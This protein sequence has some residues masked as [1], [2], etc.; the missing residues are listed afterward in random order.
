MERGWKE[1]DEYLPKR[2]TN[3]YPVYWK[4]GSELLP[5]GTPF[6]DI[7]DGFARMDR[8][9]LAGSVEALARHEQLNI[10]QRILYDDAVTRRRLE[11]NQYAI[12]TGIPT[13]DAETI[14]LTLAAQC[15]AKPGFTLPFSPD[16]YAKL[17]V[18]E[19]RMK[20]VLRAAEQFNRL[21][22]SSARPRVEESIRTIAAGGGVA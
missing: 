13:G 16:R 11:L 20:F 6:S 8:G 18:A 5:F 9:E 21:L 1:F 17:W 22:N 15:K 14:E 4:V 7:R 19:Q 2:Q 10:L 12:V 3:K